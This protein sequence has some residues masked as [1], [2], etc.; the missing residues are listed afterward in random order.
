MVVDCPAA[1][2]RGTKLI[3]QSLPGVWPIVSSAQGFL[4]FHT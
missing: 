3:N 2:L 4:T 1:E